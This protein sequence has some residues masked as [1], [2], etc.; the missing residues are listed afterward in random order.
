MSEPK[1]KT[2]KLIKIGNSL[3]LTLNSKFLDRARLE[4]GS[5]VI[6]R[7]DEENDSITIAPPTTYAG[8]K[9]FGVLS[10]AEKKAVYSTRVTPEFQEWV[11]N[12][13]KED[14]EALEKLANL[15]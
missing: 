8:T 4:E 10:V 2:Q 3:G 11:E 9:D 6:V 1:I 7:Y 15:P 13:L 14:K 5:E 12:M